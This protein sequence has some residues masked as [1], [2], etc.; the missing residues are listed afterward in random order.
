VEQI[1]MNLVVNAR[2]AIRGSR[3]ITIETAATTLTAEHADRHLGAVPGAYALLAVSD[4]G[5]GIDRA[6]Q[7]RLFEP[8][9][10]TKERGRGTGLGLSTAYGIVKQSGGDIW[11]YSEPGQGTTFKIYLPLADTEAAI[12]PPSR[13]LAPAVARSSTILV[14]EDDDAIS[15]IIQRSLASSGYRVLTARNGNDALR[16]SE[17]FHEPIDLILTDVIMPEMG[18]PQLVAHLAQSRPGI[19]AIYM[20]G[21][22]DGELTDRGVVGD[23]ASFLEKPFSPDELRR[24]IAERLLESPGAAAGSTGRGGAGRPAE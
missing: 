24:A 8:F 2:D 12:V 5:T 16:V 13:P 9:F 17:T 7:A 6:T 21:Y 15:T 4:T 23:V 3:R 11:V 18:G 14:V 22:T 1:L 10:T 20:S 19:A